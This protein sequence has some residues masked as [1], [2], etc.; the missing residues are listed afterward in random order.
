M[1]NDPLAEFLASRGR[2]FQRLED[3]GRRTNA[4]LAA[5]DLQSVDWSTIAHF[6]GLNVERQE[7]ITELQAAEQRFAGFLMSYIEHPKPD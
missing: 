4:W 6:E 3:V 2:G 5:L 7:A 1:T